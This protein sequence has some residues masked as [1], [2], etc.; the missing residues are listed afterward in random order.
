MEVLTE[1][2]LSV[3][4]LTGDKE[5][6]A[7]ANYMWHKHHVNIYTNKNIYDPKGL[8]IWFMNKYNADA[9]L[10]EYQGKTFYYPVFK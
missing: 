9:K 3:I 5:E 1:F 6:E 7:F 10:H 8:A 2:N 4:H